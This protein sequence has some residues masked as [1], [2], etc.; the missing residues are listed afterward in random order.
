MSRGLSA[1]LLA[2]LASPSPRLALLVSVEWTDATHYMHS[3]VGP[4]S[5]DGHEWLGMGDFGGVEP[6][7]ESANAA[8]MSLRLSLSGIN[9]GDLAGALADDAQGGD[10]SIWLAAIDDAGQVVEDPAGPWGGSIDMTEGE[11]GETGTIVI[12]VES[13]LA[14]WGRP[15]IRRYTDQDQQAVFPGDRG[16]EFVSQTTERQIVW[17]GR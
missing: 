15:R 3:G 10:V 12:T 9:A 11:I 7:A 16:L 1:A 5:W 6:L 2:E 14:A 17:G 4:L 8:A 13:E